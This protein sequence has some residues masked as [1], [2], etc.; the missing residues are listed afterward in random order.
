MFLEERLVKGQQIMSLKVSHT[1]SN[2][3]DK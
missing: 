2:D 3:W 1:I